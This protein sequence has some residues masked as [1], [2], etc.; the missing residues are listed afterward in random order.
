MKKNPVKRG[1]RYWVLMVLF[2]GI[3]S[4]LL[5]DTVYALLAKFTLLGMVWSAVLF[6]LTLAVLEVYRD[7]N[8]VRMPVFESDMDNLGLAYEEVSFQSR[9]GLELSGWYMPS[10]NGADVI[11]SHGF[12]AN[13]LS[14]IPFARVLN[15][16]GYGVLLYDLRA[17]AQQGNLCTWG[18]LE[19]NDLLGALDYLIKRQKCR[20]PGWSLWSID[21]RLYFAASRGGEQTAQSDCSGWTCSFGFERLSL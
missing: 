4:L 13:R 16:H 2:L 21:G 7:N 19:S 3:L 12:S 20:C 1:L 18:W 10:A 9:D 14:M 6:Y 8:P 17:W 11:L 15:E 5:I